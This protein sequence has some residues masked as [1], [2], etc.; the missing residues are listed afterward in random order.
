MTEANN[1]TRA[2]RPIDHIVLAVR[3]LDAAASRFEEWGFTL[4][5][6]AEHAWGTA[7]RL[8]QFTAG[9]FIEVLEVDRPEKIFEHGRDETPPTFSFGAH[10]RDF[11]ARRSGMAMLVLQ[12][13][14]SAADA[15]AFEAAGIARHQTFDF[16]RQATLP[17]GATV[18]VAFSLAFALHPAMPR[19]AFF[20][21]HNKFPEHF[22]KPDF[23]RHG[24][25]A[26]GIAEV[27]MVAEEP[28]SYAD[29][30]GGLSGGA[31]VAVDGGVRAGLGPQTLTMLTPGAFAAR[32][33]GERPDISD[34]P[35]FAAIVIAGVK[36]P[37]VIGSADGFGLVIELRG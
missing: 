12:G 13:T 17:D 10:N 20:T 9:N 23:Q 28:A 27:V 31:A 32:Y 15:D 25:G 36:T 3:D 1:K 16:E 29:F 5:P 34:G 37:K 11:L 30:L 18:T 35:C 4:T 6:R 24:N 19:A 21:C 2:G 14:D 7:N 33:A 8:A 22:W 26:T